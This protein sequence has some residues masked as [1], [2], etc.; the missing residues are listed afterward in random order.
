MNKYHQNNSYLKL[1]EAA[2]LLTYFYKKNHSVTDVLR[3]ILE[4]G[5]EASILF[6]ESVYAIMGRF[7]QPESTDPVDINS[8]GRKFTY[9]G[10][11]HSLKGFHRL[12]MSPNGKIFI[13]NHQRILAG[14]PE[15]EYCKDDGFYVTKSGGGYFFEIQEHVPGES[16]ATYRTAVSMPAGTEIVISRSAF[17]N[18]K[19]FNK[20]PYPELVKFL[21]E[22]SKVVHL[23]LSK[24]L[25]GN[26]L[27][28]ILY[29]PDW[30]E[31]G[32]DKVVLLNYEVNDNGIWL[33][34]HEFKKL[35]LKE[36]SEVRRL[37][38]GLDF[39]KPALVLPFPFIMEDLIRLLSSTHLDQNL[40][41]PGSSLALE[42]LR[43]KEE[44]EGSEIRDKQKDVTPVGRIKGKG[45]RR[46]D[47][48]FR[49]LIEKLFLEL[50]KNNDTDCLRPRRI[51]TFLEKLNNRIKTGSP[52]RSDEFA[53]VISK[54]TNIQGDCKIFLCD[55]PVEIKTIGR[56]RREIGKKTRPYTKKDV[57]II[58]SKLRERYSSRL[59]FPA[60][61]SSL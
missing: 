57:S 17:R 2:E 41:D 5:L 20:H 45:G 12:E 30:D 34:P 25:D 54:I 3:K 50:L 16:T 56:E 35:S 58:L 42:I 26:A 18:L 60:K 59:N 31:P 53:N 13:N 51:K 22:K 28:E 27:S 1:N 33:Q 39:T 52:V 32:R 4:E 19:G 61:K 46:P 48:V 21:H 10:D 11:L 29:L 9:I 7:V 55:P 44:G 38:P 23:D 47:L 49:P 24:P 43:R 6:K 15:A 40:I 37:F 14:K 36:K 8:Q